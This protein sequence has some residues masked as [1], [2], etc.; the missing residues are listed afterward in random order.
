MVS[1][2]APKDETRTAPIGLRVTPRLKEVLLALAKAEKRTLAS[3][4]ELVLEAH[5]EQAK[6]KAGK[7]K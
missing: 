5:A 4:I 7:A 3:Y 2:A 6:K 1:K